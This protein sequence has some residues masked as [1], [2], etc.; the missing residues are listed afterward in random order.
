MPAW[1]AT[2]DVHVCPVVPPGA[3]P[4]VGGTVAAGSATVLLNNVP[5]ARQGD[6]VAESGPPNPI[7]TGCPTVLIG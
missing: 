4:H 3:P 5:A 2:V 1:R 6:L 7:A